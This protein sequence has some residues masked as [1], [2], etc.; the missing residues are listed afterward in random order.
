V[1]GKHSELIFACEKPIKHED[2]K[3]GAQY[4]TAWMT[5]DVRFPN[6]SSGKSERQVQQL[7]KSLQRGRI[8]LLNFR[9]DVGEFLSPNFLI[10]YEEVDIQWGRLLDKWF[11][12]VI[13]KRGQSNCATPGTQLWDWIKTHQEGGFDITPETQDLE[14]MQKTAGV[15]PEGDLYMPVT[16]CD[17]VIPQGIHA[18]FAHD[19]SQ[20]TVVSVASL[21]EA[22]LDRTMKEFDE[23]QVRMA[24][25]KAQQAERRARQ[26][27]RAQAQ[28]V[29][30]EQEVTDQVVQAVEELV[31][32][33][34]AVEV[35]ADAPANVVVNSEAPVTE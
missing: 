14:L 20:W 27:E 35:V 10:K 22:G 8:A 9:G 28:A 23:E 1:I 3:L 31:Q 17:N 11:P 13:G 34:A 12:K 30:V 16:L 25:R 7:E 21:K 2:L 6:L 18:H 24:E 4:K 33:S 19:Y 32:A 29:E 15:D 26:A 5:Y